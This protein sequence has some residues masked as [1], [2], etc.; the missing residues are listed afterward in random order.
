MEKYAQIRAIRGEG[1]MQK[2]KSPSICAEASAMGWRRPTFP[3][4][5]AVSSALRGLTSLF[6]MGR[7]GPPRYSHHVY[8]DMSLTWSG[9]RTPAT[10]LS[11]HVLSHM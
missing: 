9:R 5:D 2:Q 6:G 8:P 11:S 4:I 1:Y 3:Q 10:E 7:G